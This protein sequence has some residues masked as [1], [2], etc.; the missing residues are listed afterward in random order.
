M[1]APLEDIVDLLGK[2]R[3]TKLR[4]DVAAYCAGE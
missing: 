2:V 4:E 1:E 3:G